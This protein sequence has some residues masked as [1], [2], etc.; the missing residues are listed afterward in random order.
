MA[1]SK[2]SGNTVAGTRPVESLIH[3]IRGQKV[4]LDADLASLRA[5]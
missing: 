2:R 4:M 3:I 1:T 5:C